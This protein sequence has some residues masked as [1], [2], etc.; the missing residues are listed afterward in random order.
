MNNGIVS[1]NLS[2]NDPFG[3]LPKGLLGVPTVINTP[4]HF[5]PN[6]DWSVNTNNLVLVFDTRLTF[7]RSLYGT[8][9]VPSTTI[10]LQIRTLAT[11]RAIIDWGDGS[12]TILQEAGFSTQSHTYACHGV[13]TVQISSVTSFDFGT[14]ANLLD[15][16]ALIKCNSF[17][18]IPF[19]AIS[20]TFTFAEN[21]NLIDCPETIPTGI[22]SMNNFFRRCSNFNNSKVS[23]WNTSNIVDINNAFL[24]ATN[25]NQPLYWNTSKVTSMQNTFNS[26]V[27]FQGQGLENWDVSG[28]TNMGDMFINCS[29]FNANLS[30]WDVRSLRTCPTIFSSCPSFIGSGLSNWQL[31]PVGTIQN[32]F[33]SCT[34]L[35]SGLPL[36]LSNWNVTGVTSMNSLFS[37]CTNL[38]NLTISGWRGANGC[39]HDN[40]FANANISGSYLPNWVFSSGNSCNNLFGGCNMAN[41]SGLSSWNTSGITN[42]RSM[43]AGATNLNSID[44]ISNW[45][46]RNF[47]DT[48]SMFQTNFNQNLSG[49]NVSKVTTMEAMFASNPVFAGSG[50]ENWNLAGLNVSSALNLFLVNGGIPSGQYDLILNSWASKTG[51]SQN[52][53]ANWFSPMTPNFGNSKF[54]AAGSG[55]REALRAYGWVFSDGGLQT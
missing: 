29:N 47:T 20:L 8:I 15:T 4:Y 14:S 12:T 55:A 3:N 52:G 21:V 25:F 32:M 51:L 6:T 23:Y 11:Q 16:R 27:V 43:F 38:T 2:L 9:Q 44:S 42:P 1:Q 22:T 24:A 33:S 41:V 39:I 17:G 13:Y 49:W 35:G 5:P 28:V 45:D 7:S 40:M 10:Y 54:T 31:R 26:C 53:V 34:R 18:K 30:S 48:R 19:G 50:L 37:F 36:T 46:T